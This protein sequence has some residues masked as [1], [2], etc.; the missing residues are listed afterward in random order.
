MHILNNLKTQTGIGLAV[1]HLNHGLRGEESDGDAAYVASLSEKMGLSLY[2]EKRD[3]KAYRARQ[4][5]SLEEAAREVRYRFFAEAAALFG[6]DTV[7]AGHTR[8]DNIETLL[9]HL[10][11]GSGT[12]GLRGLMP[13]NQWR[14]DSFAVNVVRPLLEIS[15]QETEDYC[16]INNLEPR[17]D[18]SNLSLSFMRNRIRRRL[19]PELRKYNPQVGE[20]L[21]R[22]A[23]IA[24]DETVLL[25]ELAAKAYESVA[26][27]EG[28]TIVFNK[29]G[30]LAQ[31]AALQR[32][33]LRKAV[34]KLAGTL[35]D[36]EMMHVEELMQAMVK[37]AGKRIILPGGMVF[38]IEYERYLLAKGVESPF[39]EL[40]AEYQLN[41]PGET[42][43]PGWRVT[44]NIT[45]SSEISEENPFV[46]CFDYEKAG[47]DLSVRTRQSGDRFQP[48]GMD[49]LKKVGQF[50]IDA[51]IPREWRKNILLIVSPG[52]VL[53]VVG[54]RMDERVKVAAAT[55][56]VLCLEFER[57]I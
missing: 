40:T 39:P 24:R 47:G 30:I 57:R 42:I 45:E 23:A 26:C 44:A 54:Y 55:R 51:R 37:P 32:L 7:A 1:A 13:Q 10:I 9:M 15:R 38:T 48:L 6:T 29:T 21:L 14:S 52:Q 53:W 49:S 33:V 3:V 19:L 16:R 46:A 28:Q 11:R 35:R 17:L 25:D 12:R 8:D 43:L 31:P 34:E 18:I 2:L 56:Q 4:R 22:S 27:Q 50:M 36:F 5:I 41:I 20:S